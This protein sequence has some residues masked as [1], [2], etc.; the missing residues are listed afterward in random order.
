MALRKRTGGRKSSA[1]KAK[2]AGSSAVKAASTKAESTAAAAEKTAPKAEIKA[3]AAKE[4]AKET[5]KTKK[6]DLTVV[7]GSTAVAETSKKSTA[8]A[9]TEAAP[10]AEA[11]PAA[12]KPAAKRGISKKADAGRKEAHIFEIDGTQVSTEDVV[13]RIKDAYKAEGHQIGRIKKIDVYYNFGER[14]AYYVINDNPEDK[15]VEF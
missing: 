11:K 10:K 5:A 13:A 2:K 3:T 8:L 14:R 6:T 7:K 9:T 15:F 4:E 1:S 12:K